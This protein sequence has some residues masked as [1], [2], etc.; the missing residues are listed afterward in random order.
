MVSFFRPRVGEVDV[1]AIDRIIGQKIRYESGGIGSYYAHI[2][3]SPSAD[4]VDSEAVIFSCPFDTEEIDHRL[5][6]SLVYK[7]G[8]F[9]CTDL[10]MDRAFSSENLRKIDF[11]I[12]IFGL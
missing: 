11:F 9:A 10:D 12:Q 1:E 8:S 7:E 6:L 3:Q 5:G 4:T 2:F